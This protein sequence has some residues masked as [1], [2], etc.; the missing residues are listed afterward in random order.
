[1]YDLCDLESYQQSEQVFI[2]S[3]GEQRSIRELNSS[4]PQSLNDP[5]GSVAAKT[6]QDRLSYLNG[7]WNVSRKILINLD[8]MLPIFSVS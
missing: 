6:I 7:A 8:M 3:T 5:Q 4:L 1:M 2:G